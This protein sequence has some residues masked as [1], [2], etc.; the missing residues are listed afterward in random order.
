M[1]IEFFLSHMQSDST[2]KNKQVSNHI[3]R[4]CF[5]V[6]LLNTEKKGCGYD[7]EAIYYPLHNLTEPRDNYKLYI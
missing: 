7:F 4:P 3:R 6:K 5:H 1:H 2:C